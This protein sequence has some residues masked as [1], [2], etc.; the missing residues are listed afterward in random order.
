MQ[1]LTEAH[2]AL[3][4]HP[5]GDRA[6]ATTDT[7]DDQQDRGQPSLERQLLTEL[8]YGCDRHA[9]SEEA[10][11]RPDPGKKRAFVGETEAGIRLR[12]HAVD[13]TGPPSVALGWLW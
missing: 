9:C 1:R 11:A 8:R 6:D 2:G 7:A 13:R 3:V 12:A 4:A 10:E 5:P